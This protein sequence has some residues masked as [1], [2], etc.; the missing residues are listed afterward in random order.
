M[1]GTVVK[2]C[3]CRD[4]ETG[5]QYGARCPKLKRKDHGAY[6]YRY[7][8][9]RNPDGKRRQ[10]WVGPFRTKQDAEDAADDDLTRHERNRHGVIDRSITFGQYLDQWLDS[11]HKLKKTTP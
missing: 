5:K 8:A 9:P 11:K 1:R 3:S 7:D 2:R 10:P 6:W 4:P